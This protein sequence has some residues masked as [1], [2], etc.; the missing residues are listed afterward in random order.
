MQVNYSV[1]NYPVS[2]LYSVLTK[3]GITLLSSESPLQFHFKILCPL[4][5]LK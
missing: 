3:P 2:E 1:I 4:K 5:S